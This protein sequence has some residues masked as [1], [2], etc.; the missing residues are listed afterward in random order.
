MPDGPDGPDGLAASL[1]EASA[2]L[3]AAL[4][5]LRELARGLA[6]PV[7][8]EHGLAAALD[9]LAGRAGL[10]VEL[11]AV[12]DQRL[13]TSVETAAY[14]VVAEAVTN[15]AKHAA[16]G[17]VDVRAALEQGVLRV[18]VHDDGSGG[19]DSHGSGLRGLADRVEALGGSLAVH[20]PPG[21]G[22]RVLA[23]IPCHR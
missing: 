18:E 13:P 12:P 3:A 4:A 5:E 16:A 15:A 10:P 14:Y 17:V 20:S 8:A 6:P 19:A 7:L 9:A 23:L 22:T 2:E 1:D 11:G 21:E